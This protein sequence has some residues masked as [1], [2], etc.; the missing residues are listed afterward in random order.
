MLRGL[1][2]LK[3]HRAYKVLKDLWDLRGLK[4]TMVQ[5]AHRSPYLAFIRLCWHYRRLTLW[6]KLE[7]LGL[8]GVLLH[9]MSITGILMSLSGS[10]SVSSKDLWVLR[11]HRV[12]KALRV[13]KVRLVSGA[14]KVILASGV[15]RVI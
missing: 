2:D 5:T 9:I 7:T 13:F 12:Y 10:M 8:L 14:L 4:A 1:W 6:V 11:D 15:L 3:D